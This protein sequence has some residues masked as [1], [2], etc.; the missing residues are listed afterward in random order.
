[1]KRH[2][3][4]F[5]L[6]VLVFLAA[7]SYGGSTGPVRAGGSTL[8]YPIMQKWIAEYRQLKGV[9]VDYASTGSGR[10]IAGMIEKTLDF[11]CTDAPLSD[12]DLK[13]AGDI[14]GVVVHVPLVMGAVA[15]IYNLPE[16][17]GPIRFS[18]A[19][20]ANIFLGKVQKWNDPALTALNATLALPDKSIAVVYRLDS[21]GT[22]YVWTDYLSKVSPAWKT[23]PGVGKTVE[24]PVGVAAK[25]NEGVAGEV[26]QI[27]GSIGY[28]QLSYGLQNEVQS[29]LVQNAVGDFVA[30]QPAAITV[31]ATES[32]STIP[33]D[34]RFSI[35]D[36]P[37]MGAYPIS[38]ATWA[39]VY[40]NQP[41][42]KG[43]DVVNFLHWVLH[44][45]QQY[46]AALY[47]APLSPALV[48]RAEEKLSQITAP[49]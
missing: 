17:S 29:G 47:Y 9:E 8:V 18:G 1:M 22:T 25:G 30:P 20:L 44:D 34:L 35:T 10:G 16:V 19:V 41:P 48:D 36:A 11:G 3:T 31:A 32:L 49:R 14:G 43:Q 12:S 28:A 33:N 42:D 5:V 7:P 37:G 4:V 26:K 2:S 6:L 15:P 21:S 23:S 38:G 13:R 27:P 46:S 45:G 24:W 40:V 39:V